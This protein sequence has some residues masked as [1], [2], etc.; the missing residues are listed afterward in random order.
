MWTALLTGVLFVRNT[1]L[2]RWPITAQPSA[3]GLPFEDVSFPASDGVRIAG[4]K[5]PGW[6]G[7]PWIIACHGLG[8]NRQDL[9][10]IAAGLYR[11]RYNLLVFDF[12]AHGESAGRVTS[13][14]WREQRDLE[15]ALA[16]LTGQPDVPDR[17]LGFYGISMGGAVGVMVA[18]RD[19]R[20][21]AVAVDSIYDDLEDSMARH[22]K[23]AYR[24]PRLPFLVFM[25]IAYWIQFQAWPA[26]M[27]P[28]AAIGRLTPRPVLLIQGEQDVRMT[29]DDAQQLFAAAAQ[30][31]ELWIVRG[32]EHSGAFAADAGAYVGR[33]R[34]FFDRALGP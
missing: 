18:A 8:A 15:G 29:V 7:R 2:P 21:G 34:A 5:I 23:L 32:A 6:P 3:L 12:R 9:L 4:W 20:L 22:M 13:F 25:K 11:V 27:S 16:Y 24:L 14:G 31:K 10:E 17:P 26:Q 33:L 19:E 30:P 1:F 28:L